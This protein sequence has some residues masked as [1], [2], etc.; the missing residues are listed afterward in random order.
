[1]DL[2]NF[3]NEKQEELKR[4]T[5]RCHTLSELAEVVYRGWP[6]EIKDLPTDLR[7]YW[8]FREVIGVEDGVIFKGKQVV[9]PESMRAEILQQLHRGHSGIEKTRLLARETVYWPKINTD[10][11]TM[12]KGCNVCQEDQDANQKEPMIASE[13]PARAWQCLGTDLFE[14]K[15]RQYLILSDYYSRFPIVK[16]LKSVTSEVVKDVIEEACSTF[17]RPDEIRSDNGPQYSSHTF[18]E[19]CKRWDIKHTT[20]SPH[21][22]QSNGYI[23]RQVRWIKST[24]KKCIKTKDN[25]QE[26]LLM[27]RATPIGNKMPSPAEIL[28]GRQ[29]A[30][31]LPNRQAYTDQEVKGWL[32]KRRDTAKERYDLTARNE[33]LPPLYPGQ[34]VRIRDYV[35]KT[36]TPGTIIEKCPEPLSYIVETPSGGKLRRNR[37]HLREANHVNQAT[38]PQMAIA[39][40]DEGGSTVQVLHERPQREEA[41]PQENMEREVC[42]RAGRVSKP[43]QRYL[44]VS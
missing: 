4:E 38:Q 39:T 1:M 37:K 2:I 23:E 7:I 42:T 17:G 22:A 13:I 36:W 11:E 14:I 9:M 43:T 35:A 27:L 44:E 19:F 5:Q 28:M 12:V 8:S 24:I 26:A 29:I 10:I 6:K 30:T 32:Q 21:Y 20:S 34:D 15:G 3:S 33:T 16:E 31:I 41:P 40:P 18:K 25:V